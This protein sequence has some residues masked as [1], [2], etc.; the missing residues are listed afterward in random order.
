[1]KVRVSVLVKFED[2]YIFRGNAVFAAQV[3]P[4]LVEAV[5]QI[6]DGITLD[7]VRVECESQE[8][9]KPKLS[10]YGSNRM[11]VSPGSPGPAM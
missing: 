11:L 4:Q 1:M 3:C 5:P 8:S 6:K 7:F 10:G 9:L 2:C